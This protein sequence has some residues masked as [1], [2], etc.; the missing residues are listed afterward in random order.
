MVT[1]AP[2]VAPM[3]MI[4]KKLASV[5]VCAYMLYGGDD[6]FDR[7]TSPNTW[8]IVWGVALILLV[9]EAMR[10]TTGWIMP[11]VMISFAAG[12]PAVRETDRCP[13]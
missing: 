1:S 7:N 12:L 2:S 11:A 3:A 13:M 8:D 9:M 5:A 10:R 4:A 6:F